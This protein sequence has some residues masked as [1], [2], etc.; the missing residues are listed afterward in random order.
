LPR[1]FLTAAA[2]CSLA[3]VSFAGGG[4]RL[5]SR[6][7][8]QGER[9]FAGRSDFD[10]K[11]PFTFFSGV[12]AADGE[13][14][15][16]LA[17]EGEECCEGEA[18]SITTSSVEAVNFFKDAALGLSGEDCDVSIIVTSSGEAAVSF[19][20]AAA[21]AGVDIDCEASF[22]VAS[23]GDAADF[24]SGNAAAGGMGLDKGCE[25]CSSNVTSSGHAAV[26]TVAFAAA[27]SGEEG[28]AAG[29]EDSV[30]SA[31]IVRAEA[32]PFRAGA[33]GTLVAAPFSFN[34]AAAESLEVPASVMMAFDWYCKINCS[35]A[36]LSIRYG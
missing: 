16:L 1:F 21:G 33:A 36:L 17:A 26:L 22:I 8:L 3:A 18:S 5:S 30:A 12:S 10:E 28:S 20:A 35:I 24:F 14:D 31:E 27:D 32:L 29:E 13:D 25:E 23:S 7:S 6:G 2:W 19:G 34:A 9:R 11:E 15:S 4:S